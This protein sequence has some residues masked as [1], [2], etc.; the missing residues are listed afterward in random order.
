[1]TYSSTCRRHVFF[2][3]SF[4]AQHV[5]HSTPFAEILLCIQLL[6]AP[7]QSKKI[8]LWDVQGHNLLKQIV[9]SLV[10]VRHQD[11]LLIWEIVEQ[12]IHHLTLKR[13]ALR[14]KKTC[15]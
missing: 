8:S 12:Q 10:G 15:N 11:D 4:E 9:Q 13:N 14:P 7:T 2:S 3:S 1:M 5:I 6:N